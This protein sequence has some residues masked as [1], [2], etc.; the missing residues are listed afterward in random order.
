FSPKAASIAGWVS[1][2]TLLPFIFQLQ[3][4]NDILYQFLLLLCAYLS[5]N[6]IIKNNIKTIYS[7]IVGYSLLFACRP[8]YISLAP[9]LAIL[10]IRVTRNI[11]VTIFKK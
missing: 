10:I 8:T 1:L 3:V 7:L 5:V 2:L 4:F 11:P 6:C 9:L